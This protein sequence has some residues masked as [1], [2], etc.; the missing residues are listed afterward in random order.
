M[1]TFKDKVGIKHSIDI[2]VKRKDGSIKAERHY[3]DIKDGVKRKIKDS[4]FTILWKRLI[5]KQ[6]VMKDGITNAGKAA[7]AGLFLKDISVNDFDWLAIGTG[8]TAFNAAQTAL[9]AETHRVAGVGTRV[10][11]A[12]AD[13]TAQLVVTFSGFTGEENVSEI[14]EFNADTGG[15][16]GMR[17]TFTALPVD[18]D[19]GDSIVMTVKVQVT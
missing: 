2:V 15:D 14:G 16:M 7:V 18:W 4:I 5:T 17:Q 6:C 9:V 12:V 19:E 10:E 13:D 8:V 11:T 3:G 1:P